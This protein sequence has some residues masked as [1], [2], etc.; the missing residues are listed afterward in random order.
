MEKTEK[1][2]NESMNRIAVAETSER[3]EYQNFDRPPKQVGV[4]HFKLLVAAFA[5]VESNASHCKITTDIGDY[6]SL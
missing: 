1:R 2:K 5:V 4:V 6:H 3:Y